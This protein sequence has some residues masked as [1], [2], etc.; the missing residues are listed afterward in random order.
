[1]KENKYAR[2][3]P[4]YITLLFSWG[5]EDKA[6]KFILDFFKTVVSWEYYKDKHL[7]TA[8]IEQLIELRNY[9]KVNQFL[10]EFDQT[11]GITEDAKEDLKEIAYKDF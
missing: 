7:L 6:S 1:M 10:D 11:N 4:K 9:D 5:K 2:F 8:F 3:R